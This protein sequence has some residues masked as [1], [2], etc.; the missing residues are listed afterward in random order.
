MSN[1]KV[2]AKQIRL[3]LLGDFLSTAE[4]RLDYLHERNTTIIKQ[5]EELPA[6]DREND[7]RS[8]EL[9]ELSV[10]IGAVH[11]LIGQLEKLL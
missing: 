9:V 1:S 10:K 6:E 7:Y 3:D 8:D 5:L 4:S 11:D 2:L